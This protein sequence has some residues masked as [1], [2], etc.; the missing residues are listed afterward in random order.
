MLR[1][2]SNICLLDGSGS[3]NPYS[4][5]KAP[6]AAHGSSAAAAGAFGPHRGTFGMAG[7]LRRKLL[8]GDEWYDIMRPPSPLEDMTPVTLSVF[9]EALN[10]VNEFYE[11]ISIFFWVTLVRLA[12]RPLPYTSTDKL[13]FMQVH[14]GRSQQATSPPPQIIRNF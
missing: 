5:G 3:I 10:D 8:Y 9:V 13:I 11:E 12:V 7:G 4:I 6:T 1:P 2:R 14:Q